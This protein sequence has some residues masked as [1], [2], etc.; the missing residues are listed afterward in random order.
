MKG[1]VLDHTMDDGPSSMIQ[2]RA[3]LSRDTCMSRTKM[4]R[5]KLYKRCCSLRQHY[6]DGNPKSLTATNSNKQRTTPPP[7]P[8]PSLKEEETTTNKNQKSETKNDC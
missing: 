5:N 8:T 1:V 6:Y 2:S 3:F 7:L 4:F